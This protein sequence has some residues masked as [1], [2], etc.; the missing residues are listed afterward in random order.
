MYKEITLEGNRFMIVYF[1]MRTDIKLGIFLS[2]SF[3][4]IVETR[5]CNT[6]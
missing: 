1:Y 3:M 2:T 6:L 4:S 5:K